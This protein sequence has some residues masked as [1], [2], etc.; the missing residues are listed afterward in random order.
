MWHEN[1]HHDIWYKWAVNFWSILI[2]FYIISIGIILFLAIC[3]ILTVPS[4]IFGLLNMSIYYNHEREAAPEFCGLFMLEI[5]PL[6]WWIVNF[7]KINILISDIPI[8]IHSLEVLYLWLMLWFFYTLL[9]CSISYRRYS[10]YFNPLIATI[11]V[12]FIITCICLIF[13][14]LPCIAIKFWNNAISEKVA[15]PAVNNMDC[16][17]W[18]D[19]IFG[20]DS[21]PG[22]LQ[23]GHMFHREC[24]EHWLQ[25][26]QVCP[27]DR[28][29][30]TR[31]QVIRVR[32]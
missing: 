21:E 5:I 23:C 3:W 24:I 7:I 27:I 19:P 8:W 15:R 22:L 12:V 20:G 11:A 13:I 29:P 4:W 30:T 25:Q 2:F 6:T 32:N 9:V 1:D 16:A 31:N 10:L 18:Q 17:I 28:K 26:N 14:C